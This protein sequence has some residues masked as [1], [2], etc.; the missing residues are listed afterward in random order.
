M[1]YIYIVTVAVL[2]TSCVTKKQFTELSQKF[3]ALKVTNESLIEKNESLIKD[4][5]LL[6]NKA[7]SIQ[8]LNRTLLTDKLDLEQKLAVAKTNYQKLK[9]SYDLLADKS[10]SQLN[11]KAK[12]NQQLIAQ[13]QEKENKLIEEQTNLDKLKNAL[14]AR[15]KR[16]EDL[17]A[18]IASKEAAMQQLK[19]AIASALKSFEGKGL[20]IEQRNGN[21][22]VS[23][24]NKLLFAPGSWTVGAEGKIAVEEIAKVLQQNPSIN[25]LI[26]GHTDNDPYIGTVIQDNWDLSVKR[27]TAIVRILQTNN[28]S[29][30]QL[31]AAGR[32]EYLPLADNSTLE[33]KSKNRRIDIVLSPNL[34]EIT[35]LLN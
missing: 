23:M 12:E 4:K 3:D 21:I 1:K 27:S 2:L 14:E 11:S 17:E 32:S 8:I 15:S 30:K 35:K 18:L 6:N 13:L 31:T 10:S 16:I 29:P 19:N 7:D 34:D 20:T 9:E 25:V 26:E 28:V 22:Y 24:E 33:G 5:S